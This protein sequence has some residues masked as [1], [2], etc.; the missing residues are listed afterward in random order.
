MGGREKAIEVAYCNTNV[1]NLKK[2]V[3]RY[4]N[5]VILEEQSKYI[6]SNWSIASY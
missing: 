5:T 2:I 6:V 4:H 1:Q 3:N